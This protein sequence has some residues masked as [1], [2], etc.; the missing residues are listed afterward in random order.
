MMVK[1][2]FFLELG[3]DLTSHPHRVCAWE[4]GPFDDI[5]D[6]ID[7]ADKVRGTPAKDIENSHMPAGMHDIESLDELGFSTIAGVTLSE[8]TYEDG[9][10]WSSDLS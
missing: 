7:F 9:T 1:S 6:A 3:V 10:I 5:R 8:V 2:E 4:V